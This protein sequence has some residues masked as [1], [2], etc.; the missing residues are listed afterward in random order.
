[1]EKNVL[2]LIEIATKNKKALHRRENL[3]IFNFA[4]NHRKE[5]LNNN[6]ILPITLAKNRNSSK[7]KSWSLCEEIEPTSTDYGV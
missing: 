6:V 7:T 1:M 5:N 4:A 3:G 2:K